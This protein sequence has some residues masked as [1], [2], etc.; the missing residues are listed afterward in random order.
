MI[1]DNGDGAQVVGGGLRELSTLSFYPVA[2]DGM[3]AACEHRLIGVDVDGVVEEG[4]LQFRYT[5]TAQGGVKMGSNAATALVTA[6]NGIV[7]HDDGFTFG[8][9]AAFKL[10]KGHLLFI[11]FGPDAP[12]ADLEAA[13]AVKTLKPGG[14][15]GT[16]TS[17]Q[18]DTNPPRYEWIGPTT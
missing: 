5:G 16:G 13:N 10:N 17:F 3:A 9:D 4:A 2:L 6:A 18:Y 8:Q 7:F 12:V 1:H 14:G 15:F 11:I